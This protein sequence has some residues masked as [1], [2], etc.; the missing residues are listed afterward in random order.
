MADIEDITDVGQLPFQG[1]VLP[2]VVQEVSGQVIGLHYITEE[3][4]RESLSTRRA[5]YW[6]RSRNQRW[7]KGDTSGDTQELQS[8][9]YDC[10]GDALLFV[11]K[12][13][14]TGNCHTG[15]FSCFFRD[16]PV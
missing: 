12:Q 3:T 4:L 15:N 5:V 10:D 13:N 11:V 16:V 8:A 1:G 7:A 2:V 14:G 9:L 6:S